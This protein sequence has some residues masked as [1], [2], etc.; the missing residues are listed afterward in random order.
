MCHPTPTDAHT[1]HLTRLHPSALVFPGWWFVSTA[2]EQGWVP[3]TCLEGQDGGQDEFSLEPE[4]GKRELEPRTCWG[5]LCWP[6]PRGGR[7][8]QNLLFTSAPEKA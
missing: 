1:S 8:P 7:R 3:A 2:E 5:A 6:S 4:E